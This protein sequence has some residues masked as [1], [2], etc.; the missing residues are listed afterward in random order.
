[1]FLTHEVTFTTAGTLIS[2]IVAVSNPWQRLNL[3]FGG[4]S[5]KE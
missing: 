4:A 3:C 5:Q 1:M 2:E